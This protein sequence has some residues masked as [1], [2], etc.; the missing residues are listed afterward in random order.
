MN[1]RFKI[2]AVFM[3]LSVSLTVS[4]QD[5]R[6]MFNPVNYAIISQTIAPDARAAGIGDVGVA[7]DPDVN[8]QHWNPAKYPFTIS[9][10]GIALNYTPWLRQLVNDID[11]AYLA[12]YYRI[13]EYSAISSSLRYFSSLTLKI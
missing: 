8:S 6:D 11:L 9:R 7:T 12:G 4:A 10:A 5:K 1:E 13:G 2:L 3:L